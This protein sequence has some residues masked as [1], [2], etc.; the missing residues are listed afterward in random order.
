MVMCNSLGYYI[1]KSSGVEAWCWWCRTVPRTEDVIHTV[2][3]CAGGNPRNNLV[4]PW[5]FSRRFCL[6]SFTGN[7]LSVEKS[8]RKIRLLLSSGA[9]AHE[10][11]ECTLFIPPR[12]GGQFRGRSGRLVR[13]NAPARMRRHAWVFQS[14]CGCKMGCLDSAS[15]NTVVA[16]PGFRFRALLSSWYCSRRWPSWIDR[17]LRGL[18]RDFF[19]SI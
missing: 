4:R 13:A 17:R 18:A 1:V 8:G 16:L 10:R 9:K 15:C 19:I 11:P 5:Y 7:L 3:Q 12:R 2:S 14:P 6:R